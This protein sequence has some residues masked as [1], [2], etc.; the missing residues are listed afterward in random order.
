[1]AARIIESVFIA[2]GIIAMMALN[3]L[4]LNAGMLEPMRHRSS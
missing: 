4:R 3:T 2:V 1:V